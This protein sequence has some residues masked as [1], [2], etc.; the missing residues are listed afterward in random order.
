MKYLFL[1]NSFLVI[2]KKGQIILILVAFIA[3][4]SCTYDDEET[5]FPQHPCDTV[6]ITY[7]GVVQ[8]IL[9]ASCYECHSGLNPQG[10]VLLDNFEDVRDAAIDGRLGGTINYK[11]GY[12]PM[13]RGRA[14]LDSCK[15]YFINTWIEQGTPDN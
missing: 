14:Q 3:L 8:P 4:F 12:P 15:L 2:K 1:K 7:S 11:P 10:D 5:L 13:P 9:V 6:A